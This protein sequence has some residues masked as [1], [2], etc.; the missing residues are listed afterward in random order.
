MSDEQWKPVAGYE[1]LYEVSDRGRVKRIAN[2][3]PKSRKPPYT[4]KPQRHN[5]G[6]L[7]VALHLGS[8]NGERRQKYHLI[9]RLVAHAFL[10]ASALSVNHKN[11]DKLDNH[12][13]NLEYMTLQENVMHA[14]SAGR[15]PKGAG[16]KG[17]KLTP[18]DVRAVRAAHAAGVSYKLIAKQYDMH[19]M[20]V[21]Q[22]VYRKTWRHVD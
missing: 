4:L 9:H 11:G 15:I 5:H 14:V 16:V 3:G 18:D 1:G 6:Y 13:D 8:E 12:L 10:G 17:A 2:F 19:P 7:M 20:N 22:V 21:Y